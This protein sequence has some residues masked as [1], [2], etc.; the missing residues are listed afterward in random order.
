MPVNVTAYTLDNAIDDKP[1]Y[2]PVKEPRA[3]VVGG[4]ADGDIVARVAGVNDVAHHGV[5]VAVKSGQHRAVIYGCAACSLVRAVVGTAD[6]PEG[7]TVQVEARRQ[8]AFQM[9]CEIVLRAYGWGEPAAPP[10][11]VISTV[12]FLSR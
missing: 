10:G 2:I 6:D 7:V 11:M 3:G 4:E 12:L 8:S 5:I 9:R 1:K